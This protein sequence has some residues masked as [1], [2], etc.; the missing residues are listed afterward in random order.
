MR[1]K[2]EEAFRYTFGRPLPAFFKITKIDD[3]LVTTAEGNAEI[4]DISPS[5]LKIHSQLTIPDTDQK[6]I[7]ISIRFTLNDEELNYHGIIVWKDRL[8]H[9]GIDLLT[10]EEEQQNLIEQL[11]IYSKNELKKG[12]VDKSM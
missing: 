12:K 11:K 4:I 6:T 5:G 8:N 2:R 9:Y 10:D 3:D 1:S 7:E